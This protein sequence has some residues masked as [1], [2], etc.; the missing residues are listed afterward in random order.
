MSAR[1][2]GRSTFA[3]QPA[4]L[5]R[6]RPPHSLRL[7]VCHRHTVLAA[8]TA[9]RRAV[10]SADREADRERAARLEC[11]GPPLGSSVARRRAL[12]ARKLPRHTADI[13]TQPGRLLAQQQWR[14]LSVCLG[15]GLCLPLP[16]PLPLC[17]CASVPLSRS[18]SLS[19]SL[20]RCV[21]LSAPVLSLR[22]LVHRRFC[23]MN[24]DSASPWPRSLDGLAG[25]M[26]LCGAPITPVRSQNTSR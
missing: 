3:W 19:L 16:L 24:A 14:S 1:R 7:S 6:P 22:P 20:S 23:T 8:C 15:L 13:S 11:G 21:R 26:K 2:N 18:L 5:W 12:A 4:L 25:S 17:L 9:G 10:A